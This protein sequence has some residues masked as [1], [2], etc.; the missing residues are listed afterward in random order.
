MHRA[1][2]MLISCFTAEQITPSIGR[3]YVKDRSITE[4][5]VCR[6]QQDKLFS[7]HPDLTEYGGPPVGEHWNPI[8]S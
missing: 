1:Q 8:R 4:Q 5:V 6:S 3:R 2:V 7:S